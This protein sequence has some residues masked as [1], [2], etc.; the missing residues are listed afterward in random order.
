VTPVRN[1]RKPTRQWILGALLVLI[2]L[3]IV[4]LL[5]RYPL[6]EIID[7]DAVASLITR[8]GAF[9]VIGFI[10]VG[11]VFTAVGLPRQLLAFVGGYTF[12]LLPGVLLGTLAAIGGCALTFTLSRYWFRERVGMRFTRVVNALNGFIRQDPF[13]KIVVLRLQPFGTNLATNLA[14]GV[15]QI[16]A[17]TFFASSLLGYLPQ[18][19]VFALTGSGVRVQ[20]STQLG[21]SLALF[22]LS[23]LLGAYLYRRHIQRKNESTLSE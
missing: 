11:I 6:D 5:Y 1:S 17:R 15:T 21:V 16:P 2:L 10:L 13:L 19:T 3:I 8:Y 7:H 20:S 4:G 9:G 23:L 14:A 12:G 18:M 22:V